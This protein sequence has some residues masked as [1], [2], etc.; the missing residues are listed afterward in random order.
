MVPFSPVNPWVFQ[1]A[2]S[3]LHAATI[4]Q[5]ILADIL[6]AFFS[7]DALTFIGE[8][9]MLWEI[10]DEEAVRVVLFLASIR[11][12]DLALEEH[13]YRM[14]LG[15]RRRSVET[16]VWRK[17][18]FL[19]SGGGGSSDGLQAH[20]SANKNNIKWEHLLHL[21]DGSRSFQNKFCHSALQIDPYGAQG[22]VWCS[23][24]NF[25]ISIFKIEC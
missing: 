23:L 7:A 17:R 14:V 10:V 8:T 18:P 13:F 3:S 1:F 20:A 24:F 6:F 19:R 9:I 4:E 25:D 12:A 22:R 16:K 21:L 11:Q 5:E 15:E 2:S